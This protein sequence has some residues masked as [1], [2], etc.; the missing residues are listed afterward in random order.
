[1]R[2]IGPSYK[3]PAKFIDHRLD[4]RNGRASNVSMMCCCWET[5][6]VL[7]PRAGRP[8]IPHGD[9]LTST[10]SFFGGIRW[11]ILNRQAGSKAVICAH[12]LEHSSEFVRR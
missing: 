2:P 10:P 6:E 4:V 5:V 9:A 7:A 8:A 12:A 1:M 11:H 3:Y